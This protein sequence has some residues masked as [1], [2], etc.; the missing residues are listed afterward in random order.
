MQYSCTFANLAD[1]YACAHIAVTMMR[2]NEVDTLDE[3]SNRAVK[4]TR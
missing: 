4:G 1:A 2:E 3:L